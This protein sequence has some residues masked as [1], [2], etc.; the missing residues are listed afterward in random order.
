MQGGMKGWSVNQ[1]ERILY[2]IQKRFNLTNQFRLVLE[3]FQCVF[4]VRIT[5][6][7][8]NQGYDDQALLNINKLSNTALLPSSVE[9][10]P[11]KKVFAGGI[12]SW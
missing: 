11:R 3:D 12:F 5:E 7:F 2:T 10:I 6:K 9:Q 1:T 8:S 4:E